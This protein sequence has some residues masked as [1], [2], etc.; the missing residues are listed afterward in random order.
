MRKVIILLR[1][2]LLDGAFG[3]HRQRIDFRQ[4]VALREPLLFGVNACILDARIQHVLGILAVEDRKIRPVLEQLGVPAQDAIADVM[5]R[6]AP[7]GRD[8]RG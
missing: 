7:N 4:H 6:P 3:I 5:K 8:V 2:H 1:Q